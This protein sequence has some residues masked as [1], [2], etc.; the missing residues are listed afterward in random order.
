MI[1]INA[2]LGGILATHRAWLVE[3]FGKPVPSDP[4]R[5]ACVR[6]HSARPDGSDEPGN[7]GTLFPH[8]HGSKAATLDVSD[9]T[10]EQVL[11]EMRILRETKAKLEANRACKLL[12]RE[13][14]AAPGS[15][16]EVKESGAEVEVPVDRSASPPNWFC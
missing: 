9:L 1:P 6:V 7:A 3:R 12:Q 10:P 15:V 13:I 16:E 4:T 11:E 2:E 14:Q 5:N 8:S